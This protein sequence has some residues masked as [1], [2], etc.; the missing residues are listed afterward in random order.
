M[1]VHMH[2]RIYSYI[3]CIWMDG[4]PIRQLKMRPLNAQLESHEYLHWNLDFQ[5]QR[6]HHITTVLNINELNRIEFN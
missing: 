4:W 1:C 6:I 5:Q 2:T 3:H